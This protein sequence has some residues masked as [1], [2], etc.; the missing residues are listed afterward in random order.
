[1][2]LKIEKESFFFVIEK[3]KRKFFA[4]EKRKRKFFGMEK[5][6]SREKSRNDLWTGERMEW[7]I[8]CLCNGKI[9]PL[10]GILNN[11]CSQDKEKV[12]EA[13]RRNTCNFYALEHKI[14][15]L[16]T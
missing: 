15:S 2:S 10:S 9:S 4:I 8:I 3:R 12:G 7:S 1:M 16:S 13:Y 14:I 6:K 11:F 5:R